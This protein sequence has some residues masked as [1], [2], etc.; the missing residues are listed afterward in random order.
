MHVYYVVWVK[1]PFG[2]TINYN[3]NNYND[4]DIDEQLLKD[5]KK[6]HKKMKIYFIV[7]KYNKITNE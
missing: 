5:I 2:I 7:N 4:N 1:K 6:I 3:D